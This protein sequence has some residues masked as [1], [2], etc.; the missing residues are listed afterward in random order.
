MRSASAC[1]F[2]LF[3]A[4]A[5]LVSVSAGAAGVDLALPAAPVNPGPGRGFTTLAPWVTYYGESTAANLAT[6]AST[7]RV[8]NIDADPAGSFT[9]AQVTQLK[10]KGANRVLS[11]LNI[12]SCESFRTYWKSVPTGFESCGANTAAQLGKYDGYSNEV[13][14]NPANTAYQNLILNYVA[15]RLVAQGVDGLFLDNMELVSHGTATTNG[16]C[17]AACSQGGLNLVGLLRQKYPKL[18]MVM[19]NANGSSTLNGSANGTP[20]AN[21]LDGVVGESVY[22]PSYD[23]ESEQA[24]ENW[25]GR[26]L[27]PGGLSFFI[28]TLDYVTA[29]SQANANT[30]RTDYTRSRSLGF[31]PYVATSSLQAVCYWGF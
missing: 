29:C 7:F 17:N 5:T 31:S 27:K 24:L 28:G 23:G 18:L 14:M 13:W 21:L 19:N 11:Y 20:F 1:F 8:I 6:L 10:N 12:G 25:T 4:V 3:V 9:P 26:K 16:P 2:S 30:V 15:P 22:L